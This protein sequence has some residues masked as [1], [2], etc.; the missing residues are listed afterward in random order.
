M[1]GQTDQ[2][3]TGPGS[4][5]TAEQAAEQ[6]EAMQQAVANM[7]AMQQAAQGWRPACLVCVNTNK[8]AFVETVLP[9]IQQQAKLA[10]VEEGSP[11][12]QQI[13]AVLTQQAANSGALPQIRS[14]DVLVNGNSVCGACF[15]PSKQTSLLLGSAGSVRSQLAVGR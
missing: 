6:A 2:P 12:W 15:V 7:M 9:Q 3:G 4:D 13:V 11:Q 8:L 5:L 14:A 1:S 10:G